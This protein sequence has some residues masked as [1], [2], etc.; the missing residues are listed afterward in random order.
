MVSLVALLPLAHVALIA[1]DS[2][3]KF[4]PAP[5]VGATHS[6][7]FDANAEA[8]GHESEFMAT[9]NT[10]VTKAAAGRTDYSVDWQ[11]I[12]F[13][14][15]G[16]SGPVDF[17]PYLIAVDSRGSL[18]SLEGGIGSDVSDPVCTFLVFYF[19]VTDSELTKDQPYTFTMP[20]NGNAIPEMKATETYL[21]SDSVDG[22]D[23]YKVQL[24]LVATQSDF[25]VDATYWLDKAG[26]VLKEDAK[27]AKLPIPN[28]GLVVS[29]TVKSKVVA[30]G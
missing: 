12:S 8:N 30:K 26:T 1:D 13:E 22:V 15:G 28:A 7:S 10:T 29:G 4:Q 20:G 3:I 25:N 6:L 27:F 9:A 5:T 19:P 21:G 23:T 2:K 14:E 18:L 16:R 17:K 11:K 24:K